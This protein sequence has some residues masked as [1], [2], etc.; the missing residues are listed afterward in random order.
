MHSA[1]T[2]WFTGLPGAGKTTLAQAWGQQLHQ[3]QR[4]VVV[5]DGDELRQG[6]TRDLGFSPADRHENMR[7]VAE[8]ARLHND[9]GVD[10]LVSPTL[11][12]RAAARQIIGSARF[13]DVFVATPLAVCQQRALKFDWGAVSL[14]SPWRHGTGD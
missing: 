2:W 14:R 9:A 1:M 5:L 3:R 4:S 13:I 10:A 6:L 11:Q 7:R 12:S 8:V